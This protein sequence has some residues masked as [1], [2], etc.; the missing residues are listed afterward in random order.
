MDVE[1]EVL[2]HGLEGVE[3]LFVGGVVLR[4]EF[5]GL[6]EE[7]PGAGRGAERH[8]GGDVHAVEGDNELVGSLALGSERHCFLDGRTGVFLD[9]GCGDYDFV[10]YQWYMNC[11]ESRGGTRLLSLSQR[12]YSCSVGAF[13]CAENALKQ[14]GVIKQIEDATFSQLY[15]QYDACCS[16]HSLYPSYPIS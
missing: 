3:T 15:E 2:E 4:R 12:P 5:H 9:P 13:H 10:R 11:E 16:A 14:E 7:V 1:V 8:D 6:G